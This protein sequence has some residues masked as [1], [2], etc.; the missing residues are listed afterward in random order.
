MDYT[1]YKIEGAHRE[2]QAVIICDHATNTVPHFVNGGDL[3][4]LET[5]MQRHIAYD[6]GALGVSQHLAMLL[7]APIVSSNFSRLVI[8]PNRGADDPTRVMRLYDGSIIPANRHI[9][10]TDKNL[11]SEYCYDPYHDALTHVLAGRADPIIL[12][13]H[14]FTKQL[15][16]YAPRPWHVGILYADDDRLAA[17]L[18][19]ACDAHDDICV[20]DNQPYN[21]KLTGDTMDRHALQHGRIHVLIEVRN[22]LIETEIN[23][24]HWAEK[25]APIIAQAIEATL[26]KET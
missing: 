8:D 3:G 11:R 25:L 17:P 26:S 23:Q 18:I 7:D 15:N 10:D 12:S 2:G 21:G 20:G 9:N 1:A 19:A 5:D 22:D 13:I 6:I 16:G 24:K 4:L 14:S